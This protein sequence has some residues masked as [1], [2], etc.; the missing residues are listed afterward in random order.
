MQTIQLA[1]TLM[2]RGYADVLQST[3]IVPYP[4]TPL[5]EEGQEKGWFRF[6]P[7]DYERFDMTEPVFKTPGMTPDEV[8]R[9]CQ[10]NYR[11]Y[12]NPLYMFQHLKR[13][14]D[15]QDVIYT[16]NGVKAVVGHLVQFAGAD[17]SG[18]ETKV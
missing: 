15:M 12:L 1:K 13:I 6:N 14:R 10:M 8:Q 5:Y 11:I 4:G 2:T 17:K 3:V 16:M 9:L 18:T 7:K